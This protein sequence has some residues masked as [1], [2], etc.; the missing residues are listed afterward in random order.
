MG[1]RLVHRSA[2]VS[3]AGEVDPGD[4][5]VH[6]QVVWTR[7]AIYSPDA[8]NALLCT[9]ARSCSTRK[10]GTPPTTPDIH[11]IRKTDDFTTFKM[12]FPLILA[13]RAVQGLFAVIIFGVS[14]Y[15]A[16]WYNVE[17]LTSSPSQVNFLVFVSVFSLLSITY[18]EGVIK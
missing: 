3:R 16:N 14:V 17:T 6:A 13:L 1:F 18:L 15:V 8:F 12:G 4:M 9:H 7:S 11:L 10:T 2:L 5:P